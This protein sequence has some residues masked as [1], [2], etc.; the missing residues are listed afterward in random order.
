MYG[1]EIQFR[2][3]VF[4]MALFEELRVGGFGENLLCSAWVCGLG[5]NC[6]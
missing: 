1:L 5:L 6:H 4:N 2:F 3:A